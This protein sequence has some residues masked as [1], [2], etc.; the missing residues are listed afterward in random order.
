MAVP[1]L[2]ESD[3]LCSQPPTGMKEEGMETSTGAQRCETVA[4][5]RIRKGMAEHLLD[6][7]WLPVLAGVLVG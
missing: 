6:N 4:L 7:L 5:A 2:R 1:P 3:M